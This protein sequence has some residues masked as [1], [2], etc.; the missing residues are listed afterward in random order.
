M[1]FIAV[2]CCVVLLLFLVLRFGFLLPPIKGLPVLLYHKVSEHVN[3]TITIAPST[4]ER[5][6]QYLSQKG[7]QSISLRQLIGNIE[8][9]GTLPPK[10]VMITFDDGYVNNLDL[11]YPLLKKYGHKAVFFIPGDGIGKTNWWD[12]VKEPLLSSEQLKSLDDTVVELG[13]H[14]FDH[15]HYGKLSAEQI[16]ADIGKCI[17]A[18]HARAISFVPALAYPYGGR[19]RD[20]KIYKSMVESFYKAGIKCAFRIGNRVNRLPLKNN[21][22]V[23]RISIRGTDSMWTFRTKLTKGRVKQV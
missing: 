11:A 20:K 2:F 8:H 14:S 10:P 12:I 6:L 23:N 17:D 4:F 19:P 7:Y 3:D 9:P 18:L 15:T 5:Q 21:F 16:D 1:I 22:E 13:L